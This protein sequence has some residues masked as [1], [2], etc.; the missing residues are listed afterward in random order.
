MRHPRPDPG[1]G[2]ERRASGI[3]VNHGR[4][5]GCVYLVGCFR[6]LCQNDK[7]VIVHLRQNDMG[8]NDNMN[9]SQVSYPIFAD[10]CK[11]G[12]QSCRK[13]KSGRQ[14]HFYEISDLRHNFGP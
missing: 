8:R 2:L 10:F 7:L 1:H 12:V 6:K 3:G 4:A 11:M 5:S 13:R 14:T 9:I